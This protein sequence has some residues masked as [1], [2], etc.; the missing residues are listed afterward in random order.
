MTPQ[1]LAAATG[2][3][4]LRASLFAEH[5]TASMEKW[6]INTPLLQAAFL[7]QIA[8][9]S[10]CLTI[11][12]ENMNYTAARLMAVWPSRFRTLADAQKYAG[13]PALLGDMVY[14]GR[15]GNTQP[16]DG[17]KYRGR[18][19]LQLTGKESYAAY[20]MSGDVDVLSNPDLLKE[21]KYAADSACW[22]WQNLG[23]NQFAERQNWDALTRRINGGLI[24]QPERLK[25]IQRAHTALGV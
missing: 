2:S 17:F 22:E 8:H 18:G 10:G 24:G 5:L 9:E 25:C 16:G 7:G 4:L 3:T 13:N 6:G 14:G 19:L 21:P 12:E 11:V 20:T 1:T 15:M 23:C